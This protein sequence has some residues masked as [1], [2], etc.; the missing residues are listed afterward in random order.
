M[1]EDKKEIQK[2]VSACDVALYLEAYRQRNKE[3]AASL[4]TASWWAGL[5]CTENKVVTLSEELYVRGVM[6]S[7]DSSA[8][9]WRS[10]R[11]TDASGYAQLKKLSLF[12]QKQ[13]H[14]SASA[15]DDQLKHIEDSF[16]SCRRSGK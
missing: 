1:G 2:A 4:H 7:K 5:A 11:Y 15:C 16:N 14:S 6:E 12:C 8:A 10:T 3:N 9:S 13:P